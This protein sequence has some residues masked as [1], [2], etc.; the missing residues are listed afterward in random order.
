VSASRRPTSPHRQRPPTGCAP[1]PPTPAGKAGLKYREQ[2]HLAIRRGKYV[3]VNT[4]NGEKKLTGHYV[5][6]LDPKLAVVRDPVVPAQKRALY[7]DVTLCSKTIAAA[8]SY[9]LQV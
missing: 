8:S 2:Q 3:A 6:I 4:F 7:C 1:L 9:T 5:D